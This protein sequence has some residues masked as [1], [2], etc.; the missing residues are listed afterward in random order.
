VRGGVTGFGRSVH[1]AAAAALAGVTLACLAGP[2]VAMD[3]AGSAARGGPH[4][5]RGSHGAGRGGV[6]QVPGLDPQVAK[7]RFEAAKSQTLRALHE[8]GMEALQGVG[9]SVDVSPAGY[10]FAQPETA[11]QVRRQWHAFQQ[12]E[13]SEQYHAHPMVLARRVIPGEAAP[14]VRL[15]VPGEDNG[16]EV[17]VALSLEDAQAPQWT[18]SQL[19][20]MEQEG[21]RFHVKISRRR[22]DSLAGLWWPG[23]ENGLT[24]KRV[25]EL[26]GRNS[27][28][29]KALRFL[30]QPENFDREFAVSEIVKALTGEQY[31]KSDSYKS[32]NPVAFGLS[33]LARAKVISQRLEHGEGTGGNSGYYRALTKPE[34]QELDRKPI[35]DRV[36][37]HINASRPSRDRKP[38]IRINI[39][40]YMYE[41]QNRA[42]VF[43]QNILLR[44][45]PDLITTDKRTTTATAAV[46][47]ARLR[48]YGLIE[49]V[50]PGTVAVAGKYRAFP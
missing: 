24:Y 1:R 4:G 34:I 28:Q 8:E 45:I 43:D 14:Q 5:G 39:L 25:V 31:L 30:Y 33:E 42:R 6:P 41:D 13:W 19:E 40:K 16:Q 22:L 36:N 37:D 9:A 50:K 29:A 44:E 32:N 10:G 27:M 46:S 26:A 47:L 18:F 15:L 20:A 49:E 17:Y 7:V 35:L 21:W 48:D 11:A 38:G 23:E 2:A 12:T 3:R